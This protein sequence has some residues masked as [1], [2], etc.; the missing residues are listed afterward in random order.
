MFGSKMN[1]FMYEAVYLCSLAIIN[2]FVILSYIKQL[3]SWLQIPVSNSLKD[4]N[5]I[6]EKS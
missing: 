1:L 2:N 6:I 4:F 5:F 3:Y